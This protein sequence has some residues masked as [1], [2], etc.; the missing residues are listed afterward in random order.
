MVMLFAETGFGFCT[1]EEG[2]STAFCVH[3]P[4]ALYSGGF[5][6][7]PCQ[8]RTR[9]ETDLGP[10]IHAAVLQCFALGHTSP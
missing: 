2:S 5:R 6:M 8:R 7:S 10:G 4:E 1:S 3:C 9:I